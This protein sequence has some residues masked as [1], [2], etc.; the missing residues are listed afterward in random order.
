MHCRYT[1]AVLRKS[2]DA[3]QTSSPPDSC[4]RCSTCKI[5]A[6][7][8]LIACF[9]AQWKIF[10]EK[11]NA[12]PPSEDP[13]CIYIPREVINSAGFAI[14]PGDVI[15]AARSDGESSVL[16]VKCEQFESSGVLLEFGRQLKLVEVSNFQLH[17]ETYFNLFLNFEE[18]EL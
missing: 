18:L 13:P 5:A 10:V 11:S 12:N 3:Y 16:D 2:T 9:A 4:L 17:V 8:V 7:D 1:G 6:M 14:R 15:E